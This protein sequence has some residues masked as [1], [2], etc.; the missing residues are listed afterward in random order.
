MK[1]VMAIMV[2]NRK[3]SAEKVQKLLTGWGCLI[4]MR[5]GLHDNVLDN[6]S[7]EGLI[8][9]ELV[10]ETEKHE[11]LSRKLNVLPGV[12]SKFMTLSLEEE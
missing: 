3:D 10:G 6:C 9:L 4:K 8:I 2:S 11:E 1:T 7:D 12:Q 5:L